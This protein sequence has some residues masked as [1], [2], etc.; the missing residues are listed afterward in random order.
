MRVRRNSPRFRIF[1][2]GNADTRRVESFV[3]S[4]NEMVRRSDGR[5][6]FSRGLGLFRGLS[7]GAD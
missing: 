5:T 6:L 7:L 3:S 1:A 2:D 4:S